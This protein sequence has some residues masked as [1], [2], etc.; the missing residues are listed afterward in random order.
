MITIYTPFHWLHDTRDLIINDQEYLIEERPERA[1]IIKNAVLDERLG[2]VIE[3]EDYGLTPILALHDPDYIEFLQHI[4]TQGKNFYGFDRP[5]LPETFSSRRPFRK[6]RHPIG[7]LGYYSFGTYSPILSGTWDAVYWSAQSAISAAKLAQT[8]KQTTYAICRPPGH[9]AGKDYYGGFCY[10]NNA[11][12][13]A[14]AFSGKTAILDIDFH[15]GNGTQDIFYSDPS[16]FYFSI[17]VD[18]D[19]EYPYFWGSSDERGELTGANTTFNFPLSLGTKDKEYLET[20]ELCLLRLIEVNPENLVI[21]LGFDIISGDP[22]GGFNITHHGFREIARHIAQI[23]R[24]G[25]R[26]AVI[27]EGGYNLDMLGNYA[28]TF[29]KEFIF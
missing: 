23:T 10:I 8:E 22:A 28:I 25:I 3:S 12:L 18:P 14:K 4:Y 24:Q 19:Q 16:V 20:L 7:Q 6:T 26:T 13:A 5:L 11:G 2:P 1:D 29:L 27:Q 9:H 17:H 21:S 15:H